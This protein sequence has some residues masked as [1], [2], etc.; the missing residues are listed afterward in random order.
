MYCLVILRNIILDVKL[1]GHRP[2]KG[3]AQ[4]P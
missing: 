4:L 1:V 2:R 3:C